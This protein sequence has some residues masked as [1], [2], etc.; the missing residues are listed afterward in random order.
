MVTH[1]ATATTT[2]PATGILLMILTGITLCYVLACWLAPFGYHRR[3]RGTGRT[4]PKLRQPC[5]R[6]GGTGRL[7]RIGRRVFNGLADIHRDGTR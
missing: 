6:C 4:G 5:R 7:L 2:S 1:A 3:C